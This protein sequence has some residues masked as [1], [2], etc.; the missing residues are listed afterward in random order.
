MR[1]KKKLISVGSRLTTVEGT[2]WQFDTRVAQ[3]FDKH[4]KQSI[5]HYES[6]QKYICSLS[7]WFIKKDSIIYDLGCSTGETAKNICNFNYDRKVNFKFIGIDTNKQMIKLAKKKISNCPCKSNI[8]FRCQNINTIKSFNK[9]DLF[10]S[11]LLFPFLSLLQRKNLLNK[12]YK[13][14]NIGGALIFIDKINA[15]T[16]QLQDVFS[17]VY[18]D[19]KLDNK[20]SKSQILNKAK[21]LRGSMNLF[22]EEEV[23]L[24]CKNVGFKKIDTFFRWF[25]FVGFIVLK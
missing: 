5:P 16:P 21:S 17:Q 19:F 22:Q 10:I 6:I 20:L 24:L 23:K 3:Y 14:L 1:K 12:I 4:V 15:N 7:E 25:N 2:S 11:I 9:S 8:Q 13:S 18:F